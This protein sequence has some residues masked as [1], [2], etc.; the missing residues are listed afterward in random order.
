MTSTEPV[1]IEFHDQAAERFTELARSVLTQVGSFGPIQPTA[2]NE[3]ELHPVARLSEKDVIGLIRWSPR[4]VNG[5]GQ[6]TGRYWES[7][8]MRVGWEGEGYEAVKSLA[9]RFE[10]SSV[11]KGRVSSRFVLDEVFT[12]LQDTLEA[13]RTDTLSE[14]MAARCSEEIKHHEIW[15]PVYRTYSARDFLIGNVQF[16]T[17]S[18][19]MLDRWY[20]R[21]PQ[22]ELK[23]APG[24]EVALNRQRSAL[25]ETIAACVRVEAEPR[26]ASETAHADAD[27]AIALLRFLSPVNWTC[28]ITSHCLPIGKEN[29]HTT[30]DLA[31]EDGSIRRIE[32]GTIEVGPAGWNIDEACET[33][34]TTG[35]LEALHSLA[36]KKAETEFRTDLYGALQLHARHSVAT[37][38]AHKLVFVVAAAESFFLRNTSEPIQKNL[39]ER[40]AFLIGKTI[41][42]RRKVIRNVD[43]FYGLRSRLIH[44]GHDV[45]E[46]QKDVVDELFFNVW[47]SFL[48]LLRGADRW[49]TRDEMFTALENKKLA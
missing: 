12:W 27:E 1:K 9:S 8:G 39:G 41:D 3:T 20:S 49:C 23:C 42:E 44:H 14:F 4:S 46:D 16:R 34:L 24:A 10:N 13:K 47:F 25:Q 7:G 2:R 35:A 32:R 11:L 21:I 26:K 5:L 43:E 28:R 6:E 17:I 36:S 30:M 48:L 18:R 29:T 45:Q 31:V 37:A 38:V 22:E 19:Q 40:M 33:P 15:V